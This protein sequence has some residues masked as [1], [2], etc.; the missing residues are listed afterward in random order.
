MAGFKVKINGS[1]GGNTGERFRIQ[2][3]NY[4]KAQNTPAQQTL[5]PQEILQKGQERFKTVNSQILPLLRAE[6]SRKKEYESADLNA[7]KQ[8]MDSY[9][10]AIDTYNNWEIPTLSDTKEDGTRYSYSDIQAA[11]KTRD[12]YLAK[13]TGGLNI[14]ETR[15]V[16]KNKSAYYNKVYDAQLPRLQA[17]QF[18]KQWEL[19]NYS[20]GEAKSG[21]DAYYADK[22]MAKQK[23]ENKQWWEKLGETLATVPSTDSPVNVAVNNVQKAYKDDT[24]YREP[25]DKWSD[26]QLNIF[27]YLYSFDK[28]KA[29]DYATQVNN[30]INQ[31]ETDS[32]KKKIEKSATKNFGSGVAHALGAIATAPLGLA[33]LI[34]AA[35][36]YSARGTITNK[37]ILTP[38][39]YSEAVLGAQTQALNKWS[40]TLS[41]DVPVLGGKGVGDVYGLVTSL[42]QSGLSAATGSKAVTLI[43]F[44]GSSAA[45]ALKEARE[46]GIDDSKAILYGVAAGLAEAI[47]EMIAV[48]K[49]LGLKGADSIKGFF[50]KLKS[51]GVTEGLTEGM[52]SVLT[53]VSDNIINGDFS[54]YN[55]MKQEYINQGLA[56]TDASKKAWS[57]IAEEIAF[58]T[59]SGV[60]MGGLSAAPVVAARTVKERKAE[61]DTTKK[62]SAQVDEVINGTHNPRLDL[63]V[64]T[65]SAALQSVKIPNT[66]ILMRNGKVSEILSKHPEMSEELIKAIPDVLQNPILILKSKTHPTESVVVIGEISTSKG[67]MI[68]PVWVNQEG[69]Y[70]DVDLTEKVE[71]TNFVA[72]AYGRNIKSLLEYANE[73]EGFIYQ[74]PDINKVRQ[75]LARNGL[76]LP[77]PLKLS[78]SD[79][80]VPQSEQTVNNNIPENGEENSDSPSL[81]DS[82]PTAGRVLDMPAISV[83][84]QNF[85]KGIG[86]AFGRNVEFVNMEEFLKEHDIN[87]EK[88]KI[89]P[90][91]AIDGAGNIY[92]RYNA[93]KPVQFLFKHELTHFGERS[94]FYKDFVKAV[95]STKVYLEW[96][97]KTTKMEGASREVMEAALMKKHRKAQ[98]SLTSLGY[99]GAMAEVIADFVGEKCF[100]ESLKDM[101]R[102]VK[103]VKDV[104]K[105]N[106]VVRFLNDFFLWLKNHLAEFGMIR[107]EIELIEQNF[108][109]MIADANNTKTSTENGR[110]LKFGIASDSDGKFVKV[111]TNQEIFDGKSAGEMQEIAKNIILDNFKGKVVSVG[112]DGK[113]YVNKRSAEEYAYPA[114]RRMDN[115]IKESKMRAA[116]EFENLLSVSQFIENQPDDGRHPDATGGW[117]KY[118]TRFEVNGQMFEGE[119]KIKVTNR[120]YVFYDIS[121]IKRTARK[122]GLTEN[123]SAAASGNPSIDSITDEQPTVNNNYMQNDLKYSFAGDEAQTADQDKLRMALRMSLMG[124][125]SEAI[126]RQTGWFKSYDGQWRFEID[127]SK[128]KVNRRIADEREQKK[129]ISELLHKQNYKGEELTAEEASELEALQKAQA[130]NEKLNTLGDLIEHE[131]L[132]KA[133]PQLKDVKIEIYR[134][135]DSEEGSY[136][137]R[138]KTIKLNENVS[139]Y[140]IKKALMHE[141]Q[142][143][144]QHIEGFANGTSPEAFRKQGQSLLAA[145]MNYDRTAGEI[146]AR[147]A[148]ERMDMSAE[149]RA[150]IRPD[151]DRENVLLPKKQKNTATKD[152]ESYAINHFEISDV[153]TE[154]N[155]QELAKMSSV[156][157]VKSEKLEK[158]GK[159]PSELF[160]DFFDSLGNSVY[161]K[162]FGDIAL[163]KSSV[164]SEIRHGITAEKIASI[165]AIPT[166]LKQ[167]KI[168]FAERKS[169]SDVERIVVCAPIK[170][171]EKPYYMGVMLQ[172]DTQNQRLYLHNVIIEEEMSN[173]SQADLLTTG[174]LEEN[175]HL[176]MTNILQKALSVKNKYM[177]ESENYSSEK[178]DLKFSVPTASESDTYTHITEFTHESVEKYTESQYN[179]FGWVRANDVLTAAEYN[180]LLSRYADYKH[181]KDRY[182]TTRF[183]EAVIHSSECPDVIMYVKGSIDSPQITKVVRIDYFDTAEIKE[184]IFSNERRHL[185][186]PYKSIENFYGQEIFT[187]CK[188]R[189]YASFRDYQAEQEGRSSQSSNTSGRAEQNRERSFAE[190]EGT[191]NGDGGVNSLKFSVTT[192]ER[193]DTSTDFPTQQK[194]LFKKLQSGEITQQEYMD[195]INSLWERAQEEYG[196]IPDGE[197]VTPR[198]KPFA[199]PKSVKD[200]TKVRQH[201]RT[202]LKSGRATPEQENVFKEMILD[203]K[204]SYTPTSNEANI[205]NAEKSIEKDGYQKAKEN[206]SLAVADWAADADTVAEGEALLQLAFEQKNTVDI[207]NLAAQ[208]AELGTHIGQSLQA[209]SL[210]K[211]MGGLGQLVYLERCVARI[212]KSL[213]KKIKKG[214][215][216]IVKIDE[217]LAHQLAES[218]TETEFEITY[219]AIVKD[220]A[221]QVP[222][223]FGDKWNA[224]RYVCMLF[225]PVTHI[226]N[227]SGNAIFLPAVRIKDLLAVGMEKTVSQ[228]KR[229]KVVKVKKEYREYAEKDFDEVKDLITGTGKYNPS[230]EIRSNQ[231]IFKR[232]V[233]EATRKFNFD[234]LEKEDALFLKRHYKH[235]L[236]GYLQ[237]Q[238]IDLRE[239]TSKQ[240]TKA[241][242]YAMQEA[243]KA[244][245]RDAS[246]AANMLSQFAKMNAAT[247][248][249]V[250]G[251]LPYKKTPINII[252][253]GVEYSPIGLI[254]TLSKGIYDL[255]QGNIT[256]TQFIDGLASGLT[257]TGVCIVGALLAALGVVKGGFDDEE[258]WFRKLNGEQEY[259]I[260]IGGVS[261]TIDWATPASIPLFLGVAIA[262]YDADEDADILSSIWNF[263]MAAFEPLLNLS[264]LSGLEDAIEAVSYADDGEKITSFLGTTMESYFAQFLPSVFGK[265]ANLFDDTR[266]TTYIDKTSNVPVVIQEAW[267]KVVAK[268]PIASQIRAEYI[269]AWGETKYTGNFLQR[270]FQQFVS[271][272]Y[273][274]TV[275]VDDISE[276]LMRLYRQTDVSG[277][278]PSTPQKYLKIRGERRDLSKEEYFNYATF[279]GQTQA[280]LV[281]EAIHNGEY[282]KLTD[283]QKAEVIK[284][285]YSY[286]GA[287]AKCQLE[288]SYEEL[289]AME[290]EDTK[291]NLI[292]TEE[293]YNRLNDKARQILIDEYFMESS[294][295][296]KAYKAAKN[297][298]SVVEYFCKKVKDN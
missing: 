57:D 254:K 16:L 30:S 80:T 134:G 199:V 29:F 89:Y 260:E 45:S 194:E 109:R 178:N 59:L 64:G 244:T 107:K 214:K 133:Y 19:D 249:F 295:N 97:Q 2:S 273:A 257:G 267:N 25:N 247:E 217:T 116:A 197:M 128:M 53:Q 220:I 235:A 291:G 268:L 240:L 18:N 276:E 158:T 179:S 76:Q 181:N 12:E 142:H 60:A 201:V 52:T 289:A 143:A 146:E 177:Q 94:K 24:S 72:S 130:E 105:R 186:Q 73:N 145:G 28:N 264:L 210:V 287:L 176:S 42:L 261:Y 170:I 98:S 165:E 162:Q 23:T 182:P 208:L 215:A 93:E 281:D 123:N 241:R 212:N 112:R 88:L 79:I 180:T 102:L 61:Y 127:D 155:M 218:K 166:V 10:S 151:I 50:N 168:I 62:F 148:A 222:S 75:L 31:A 68:V 38:H 149:E 117:D 63:Y 256:T 234:L 245:Y 118:L 243:M 290:G 167:G 172:R 126:Q 120:G 103:S 71:N 91:G 283:E 87:T 77:T 184:E 285:I 262:E 263:G 221:A 198:N 206:W 144:I 169:G 99:D 259:S 246:K 54:R 49:L 200:G 129:R 108:A 110:G 17:E 4:G 288:Y 187:V 113:A 27:G 163:S 83:K 101:N 140:R 203:D 46:R 125:D 237:A 242:E 211:R 292:L 13:I 293:K 43:S 36:E 171:G 1:S 86:K 185:P 175:E 74:S 48:D 159:K 41:E 5:S 204:F 164:K 115:S 26:E 229:T 250:E 174:A 233:L 90:E 78:D 137:L 111:E 278:F 55:L 265:T 209:M 96:L 193:A 188:A 150:Q 14:D 196:T 47:P 274:S 81:S 156:Y 297:G 95:R 232:T 66:P 251:L 65:P 284:D 131:E 207:V 280:D 124:I 272:G 39:D 153:D 21:L 69:N 236:G 152:G 138:T 252:K 223:T 277:L 51:Q 67:E 225:N 82:A 136:S 135:S 37:G 266:R 34:D 106:A 279:K 192:A 9:S 216:E 40:G 35:V 258:K 56:E 84:V 160:S 22:N 189:D 3:I 230:D 114:N 15:K 132:F 147:D 183:G 141:I 205:K 157:N 255:R 294:S 33:D 239:V 275:N 191:N 213:E 226:R 228:D 11:K 7:L 286:A 248:I 238:G 70:I 231:R 44:F 122:A 271:P 121:K 219:A 154:S 269:D 195:G 173:A 6:E 32:L 92:L 8:D 298:K 58:D 227:L 296:V 190:G 20:D 270:F 253:R 119:V 282:A 104:E 224:L 85:V 161:V 100:G 202:I 139:N